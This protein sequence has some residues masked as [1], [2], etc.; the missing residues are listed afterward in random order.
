V[1]VSVPVSI[2]DTG[3][4]WELSRGTGSYKIFLTLCN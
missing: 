2:V 4:M 3:V 1:G